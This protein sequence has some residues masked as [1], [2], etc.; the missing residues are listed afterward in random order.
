[1][2]ATGFGERSAEAWLATWHAQAMTTGNLDQAPP[3]LRDVLVPLQVR[4]AACWIWSTSCMRTVHDVSRLGMRNLVTTT[5]PRCSC[6]RCNQS[7][8][9]GTS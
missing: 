1:M 4:S 8:S 3:E 6:V 7:A 9:A 5:Y 2:L